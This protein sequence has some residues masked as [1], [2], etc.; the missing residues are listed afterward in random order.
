[1]AQMAR[2]HRKRA[3]YE[4][5]AKSRQKMGDRGLLGRGKSEKSAQPP[6]NL[7]KPGE[8]RDVQQ[9]IDQDE[10]AWPPRRDAVSSLAGQLVL[11]L[12]YPIVA[13]ILLS[14]IL[15][16]AGAFRMGQIYAERG[17]DTAS[18]TDAASPQA[19]TPRATEP[20]R[21]SRPPVTPERQPAASKTPEEGVLAPIGDHVI[22][23]ATIS[24]GHKSD[25]L[26]PVKDYFGKN[27]IETEVQRRGSYYFLVTKRRYSRP[28]RQ[29]SEG[30]FALKKI[31]EVGAGYVAP[32]GFETFGSKPF[33]D[34]Y[35]M[36]L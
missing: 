6:T 20:D 22:V 5:I 3:L 13:V 25:A 32:A 10:G 29:G 11:S 24:I 16:T 34:A 28:Q 1:M 21:P 18:T 12:S 35:A 31:K 26:G 9:D 7:L 8:N 14:L 36:K 30:Y 23:I 19:R 2:N 33:Q 27:G 15:V 17:L 4:V